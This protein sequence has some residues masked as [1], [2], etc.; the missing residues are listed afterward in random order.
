M[1]RTMRPFQRKP[2]SV[3]VTAFL[4]RTSSTSPMTP[5]RDCPMTVAMA[6]PRTPSAG[7]PSSP[8]IRMGSKMMLVTAPMSC[9]TMEVIM[10]PVA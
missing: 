1:S 3:T 7:A 6:A 9:S 2:R 10:L 5:A 4:P 8:K